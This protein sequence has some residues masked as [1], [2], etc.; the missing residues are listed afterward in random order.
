MINRTSNPTLGSRGKQ[1]GAVL[2]IAL[3]LL[4]ILTLLGIS[5]AQVTALQER[6]ASVYRADQMAFENA[7]SL[8]AGI[9]RATTGNNN[10]LLNV[11]CEHLYDGSKQ[12]DQWRAGNNLATAT[13]IENLGRGSSFITTMGSLESGLAQEIGD[14]NCLF[15]QISAQAY[16]DPSAKTSH[17]IVQSIFTP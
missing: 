8:L 15:L 13:H 10:S 9:E 4:I 6:M 11:S 17:S 14:K 12:A 3:M 5:A 2:F 7:E 16:D 1:R